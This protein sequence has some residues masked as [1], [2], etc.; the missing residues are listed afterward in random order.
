MAKHPDA[1]CAASLDRVVPTFLLS[2]SEEVTP[3]LASVALRRHM[4]K[5]MRARVVSTLCHLSHFGHTWEDAGV[6]RSTAV[7]VLSTCSTGLI[8]PAPLSR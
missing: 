6:L 2:V 1:S 8:L 3:N 7:F 4:K 5:N